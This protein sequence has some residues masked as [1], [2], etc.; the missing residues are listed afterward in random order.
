MVVADQPHPGCVCRD[1][2][3]GDHCELLE[4]TEIKSRLQEGA[5]GGGNVVV[6]KVLFSLL[7]IAM[8]C[9]VT[10]IA[11]LLVKARKDYKADVESGNSAVL[12]AEMSA[13][14][15]I[16]LGE[17]DLEADGSG[18]LGNLSKDQDVVA[19]NDGVDADGDLELTLTEE[20]D[21]APPAVDD[22]EDGVDDSED[23]PAEPE[24]V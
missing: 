19:D 24:I 3:A 12:P 11:V 17:G 22:S 16:V 5:E 10:G 4:E 8:G 9:V 2:W 15:K 13:A 18:T 21:E 20:V 7:I 14:K 23:G 6:G 1:G